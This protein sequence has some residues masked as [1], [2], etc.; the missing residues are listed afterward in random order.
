MLDRRKTAWF[1]FDV[2]QVLVFASAFSLGIR[3][4]VADARVVP[5]GSMLPTIQLQD[6]LVVDKISYKFSKVKRGD[7][8]VFL[9]PADEEQSGTDWVKRVIGLPGE[10]VE[11][12][13][14]KVFINKKELIESYELE[15]PNYKYGPSVVPDGSYFVLGDN[16]NNSRDSHY[17]GEL[18]SQN[19]V[20][21]VFVRYWPF[22]RFGTLAK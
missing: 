18:P 10:T 21:K 9:P 5:T 2:F 12:R 3:A 17:W 7:V 8:I 4:A 13:D 22:D 14:G 15:K 6:R 16:R 20:G 19:I 1:I 11:V